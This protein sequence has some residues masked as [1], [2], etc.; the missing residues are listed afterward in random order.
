M[1]KAIRQRMKEIKQ[2]LKTQPEDPARRERKQFFS[3]Y[4]V[5]QTQQKNHYRSLELSKEDTLPETYLPV[6]LG[7]ARVCPLH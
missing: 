6:Q 5:K 4:P 2:F 7:T 1:N 3:L